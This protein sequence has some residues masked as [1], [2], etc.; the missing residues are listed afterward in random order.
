MH[1]KEFENEWTALED[2]SRLTAPME[3]HR[4][5][6]PRCAALVEDLT[7]ILEQAREMRLE[8]EPPQRVWVAIRNQMEREGL[9]REPFASE[10]KPRWKSAPASAWLFR[11]PM[12]LAYTAVFFVAV[13]VMY[14]HSLLSGPAAPPLLVTMPQVPEMALA[15]ADTAEQDKEVQALLAKVPKEHRATIVTNWNQVNSSIENL[16][17]FVDTHP[18]DPFARHQLM[19]AFQ[20]KEHLRETLVRWEQF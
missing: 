10:I 5:V 14:M 19:N 7:A 12:G 6:C 2:G 17:S 15:K 11:L 3:D 16:S 1:C 9:I 13:G 8:E 4:G 18:D 20:Q